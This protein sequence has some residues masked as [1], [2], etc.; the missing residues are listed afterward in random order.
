MNQ[1]LEAFRDEIRGKTVS[2]VGLGVSNTPVIDFLLSCGA[3]VV[4]RDKKDAVALGT[5][6]DT[7]AE[8][9]VDLRLGAQY[10][11]DLCEDVIFKA[12]G[13]RPDLPEFLAAQ[14]NGSALTSEMEVFLALCPAAVF[15]VTG[16]D[17][18][19]TTTTLIYT[20]L[21]AQAEKDGTGKTV[22]VGGNIGKPLLPEIE[23]IAEDDFVVLELSSFQLQALKTGRSL[24]S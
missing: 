16:S 4:G 20:M 1:K 10:L 8:K 13:I 22:W 6:A 21:K 18:K 19:T 23:S 3:S 12:P 24:Q 2:V 5:L 11:D 17:G 15:A 14:D 7:L 9:G